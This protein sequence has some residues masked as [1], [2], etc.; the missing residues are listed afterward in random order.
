M[1]S[2]AET[3]FGARLRKL[4][5]ATEFIKTWEG[6][7]PP[8]TKETLAELQ[9]LIQIIAAGNEAETDRQAKY[10]REVSLRQQLFTGEAGSVTKMLTL[11]RG[12]VDAQYGRTSHEAQQVGAIIKVM[13]K[14]KL[15]KLPADPT[16]PEAEKTVSQSEKSFGSQTQYF[17]D[18]VT[19]L[20]SFGDYASSTKGITLVALQAFVVKLTEANNA[21]AARL[22]QMR[23]RRNERQALYADLQD[24]CV[25]IKA[26]TRSQYGNQSAEYKA[27]QALKM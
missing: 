1:S 23:A 11:I 8:R 18:L 15:V 16:Q 4:Q 9:V 6:Y 25:R 14:S 2:K 5:D 10:S 17:S 24:R 22:E 12:A 27:L 3:S 26:Y 13:R 20:G 21:V 7:A 19:T